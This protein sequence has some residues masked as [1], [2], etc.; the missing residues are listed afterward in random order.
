[1]KSFR[2][3]RVEKREFFQYSDFLISQLQVQRR[4][5]CFLLDEVIV[6]GY[7]RLQKATMKRK[8]RSWRPWSDSRKQSSRH[9]D[10]SILILALL[11][12][13]MLF[14]DEQDNQFGNKNT[15]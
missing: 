15:A 12:K 3:E 6:C 14:F 8:H 10:S 7:L 5:F 2:S 13:G 11:E 9:A 4:I 1:M